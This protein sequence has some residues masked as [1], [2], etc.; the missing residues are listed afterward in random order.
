VRNLAT[1]ASQKDVY[2]YYSRFGEIQKC[3][4]EY[5]VDGIS[6]GFAYIQFT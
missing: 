5:F 2:E 4:L 1:S 3:K 6:R